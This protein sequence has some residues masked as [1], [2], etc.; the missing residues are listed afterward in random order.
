VPKW[1]KDRDGSRRKKNPIS[2]LVEGHSARVLVENPQEI[3][4][5]C[6]SGSGRGDFDE[7]RKE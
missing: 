3:S 2:S 6:D 5:K 4:T 1:T 7:M